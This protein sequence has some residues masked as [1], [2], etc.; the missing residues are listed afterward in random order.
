MPVV[1]YKDQEFHLSHDEEDKLNQ[2]QMISSFPED[3]LPQIIKLLRN[4]GWSLEPALGRYFDGTWK[5]SFNM[6]DPEMTAVPPTIPDRIPTP[7]PPSLP[8]V[9]PNA[10]P[11]RNDIIR[12]P[13]MFENITN[14]LVPS[15]PI[16]NALPN[17]FKDKYRHVGLQNK[18]DDIW[19]IGNDGNPIIAILFFLPKLLIKIG[20]GLLSL[21]WTIITFGFNSHLN[22]SD[23][24]VAIPKKPSENSK[25]IELVLTELLDDETNL[26]RV[27]NLVIN[28]ISFN[29]ALTACKEEFKYI[30]VII[31]GET[32]EVDTEI[33]DKNSQLFIKKIL[34]ND[35]VLS[36]LE[37]MKDD[38]LIYLHQASELEPWLV[39]KNMKIKYT[40]ECLLI[41]NVLN[42]TGSLNGI[43]RPSV[44]AKIRVTTIKKFL[45]SLTVTVDR[46][47]P[48]LVVSRTEMEELKLARQ[49]KQMQN[50]A[51]E[52]SLKLD[53][54]KEEEKKKAVELAEKQL[55]EEEQRQRQ[56]KINET[57]K[58]LKWLKKC[59]EI[60]QEQNTHTIDTNEKIATLQIRTSKGTRMIKK[61]KPTTTLHSIYL[62]VGCH[63]YLD[64]YSSDKD[65]LTRSIVDMVE[66][67]MDNEALLCFKD[68]DIDKEDLELDSVLDLI[69]SEIIK[70][71]VPDEKLTDIDFDFE[72]VS[73]FP[74][75]NVPTDKKVSVKEVKE[76]W[77]N[78]S[79]LVEEII[80]D[81][82]DEDEDDDYDEKKQD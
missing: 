36:K 75:F 45:N 30:L 28:Q 24:V 82:D 49:L 33:V 17:N 71:K 72:L 1:K 31:I 26:S 41:G 44:L 56:I 16:V 38:M 42:S 66:S 77:P 70:L 52:E 32:S 29:E 8:P 37:S 78:G 76:L 61:F 50:D 22:D 81:N 3:E 6:V 80:E 25:S 34:S 46:F 63:L 73:P 74:R 35:D 40:P 54:K 2:F 60:I 4:H 23:R 5:D 10:G 7:T 20:G 79:L 18:S 11:F 19:N 47:N 27:K 39:C 9:I 51:Y 68:N 64:N 48:E 13:F 69:K 62:H 15:L 14:S 55:I 65:E 59:I 21:I 53:R 43:T 57:L 67:H 58:H 12:D